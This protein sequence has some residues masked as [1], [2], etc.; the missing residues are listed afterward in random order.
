MAVPLLWAL[1]LQGF[2]K[3]VLEKA[4]LLSRSD[5]TASDS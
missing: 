3:Q 2:R 1:R 5:F 4:T